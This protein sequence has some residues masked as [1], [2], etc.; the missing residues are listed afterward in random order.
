MKTER[1][2]PMGASPWALPLVA[3]KNAR[4]LWVIMTKGETFNPKHI[5][6]K[7]GTAAVSTAPA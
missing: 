1:L 6:V 2:D 7:P 3:S 5:S 4:I